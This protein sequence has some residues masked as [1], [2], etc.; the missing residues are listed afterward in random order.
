MKSLHKINATLKTGQESLIHESKRT[1]Y[2]LIDFWKWSVSDLLSNATRGRFAEFI[3]ATATGVDIR[4][5]RDEWAPF[6]LVTPD[7][8]KIEVKSAAYIQSWHQKE[9]SKISFS[10][11]AAYVWDNETSTQSAV[12]YRSAD[13]YVFCLLHHD[14]KQTCDPLNL[15]HWEFYIVATCELNNYTRSLSSITLNSLKKLTRS[16]KYSKLMEEVEMKYRFNHNSR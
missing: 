7:G 12:A 1:S 15:D 2:S 11:K 13:V 8:I 4:Q 16:I 3:V 9:L 14:N 5:P 10:T 6:D